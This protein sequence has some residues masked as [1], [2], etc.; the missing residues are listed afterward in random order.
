[1]LTSCADLR[2]N[3]K[4]RSTASSRRLNSTRPWKPASRFRGDQHRAGTKRTI[5]IAGAVPRA[6]GTFCGNCRSTGTA[7][8]GGY[9]QKLASPRGACASSVRAPSSRRNGARPATQRPLG[10]RVGQTK[11]S[12]VPGR[13]L[14]ARQIPP[15]A[16]RNRAHDD[17]RRREDHRRTG[18]LSR[19]AVFG[20]W[21]AV[22]HQHAF[23]KRSTE[24]AEIAWAEGFP[25]TRRHDH[26]I[27]PSQSSDRGPESHVRRRR[28][29]C[30][31]RPLHRPYSGALRPRSAWTKA[32]GVSQHHRGT[33]AALR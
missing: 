19:G 10:R 30:R 24:S 31:R 33:A 20:R 8:L 12:R 6:R 13:Q 15:G 29:G 3:F 16:L 25:G 4:A 32:E 26:A 21:R 28:R 9:S 5:Q 23:K 1:M 22:H 2:K 17:H 14:C 7:A 11:R 27:R 18:R